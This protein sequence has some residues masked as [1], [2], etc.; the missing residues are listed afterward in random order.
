MTGRGRELIKGNCGGPENR[1]LRKEEVVG[2]T[3]DARNEQMRDLR[4]E[5]GQY[6]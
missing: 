3:C 6:V 2:E 4:D 5:Q 1:S